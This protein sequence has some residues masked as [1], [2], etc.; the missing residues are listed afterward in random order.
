MPRAE[1]EEPSS[2]KHM[3]AAIACKRVSISIHLH[4]FIMYIIKSTKFGQ[5]CRYMVNHFR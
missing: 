5:I 3:L 2:I 1:L 4:T